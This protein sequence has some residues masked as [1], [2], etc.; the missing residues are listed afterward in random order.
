MT[1]KKDP[2]DY[3][4]FGRPTV[5]TQ[6]TLEKLR[7]CFFYG[8]TDEEACLLANISTD[9]L[10]KYQREHPDFI[11]EKNMLKQNPNALA[12]KIIYDSLESGDKDTAKWYA[13]RKMK[14]EFSTK[15]ENETEIKGLEV[16]L[17]KWK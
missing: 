6:Q 13:E 7:E 16:A 12:R 17:V 9:V 11:N 14:D 15:I 5:M 8:H 1:A 4:K 10:Y 2:K 3:K